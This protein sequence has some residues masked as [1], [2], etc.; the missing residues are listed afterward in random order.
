MAS[1]YDEGG[2]GEGACACGRTALWSPNI[3]HA[4]AANNI[5][6][7]HLQK[8]DNSKIFQSS[9]FVEKTNK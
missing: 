9:Y 5:Q 6:F 8:L 7:A 3:R 2:G 1:G 4:H